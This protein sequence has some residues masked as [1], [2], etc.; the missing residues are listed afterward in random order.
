MTAVPKPKKSPKVRRPLKRSSWKRGRSKRSQHSGGAAFPKVK[1]KAVRDWIRSLP[2]L[3]GAQWLTKRLSV[4]DR[5]ASGF[6]G[7]W[8]VCWGPTDPAHVGQ[9]QARGAP[10]VGHCVP[11]CR[12]AHQY[13]DEHRPSWAKATELTEGHMGVAA[14]GYA[15]RWLAEENL[16]D[17]RGRPS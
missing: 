7:F 9:H 13:Y 14:E 17:H 10:D 4:M 11:L 3:L 2:C 12:A 15:I 6:N 16:E 5:E 1:N 8:H